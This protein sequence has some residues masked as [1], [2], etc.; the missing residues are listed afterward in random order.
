MT[1]WETGQWPLID[2][3]ENEYNVRLEL[4]ETAGDG[5]QEYLV[6]YLAVQPQHP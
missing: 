5:K 3:D 2:L 1:L 6:Y 4:G